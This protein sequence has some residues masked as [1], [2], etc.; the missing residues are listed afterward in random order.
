MV[1]EL[2]SKDGEGGAS[3]VFFVFPYNILFVII[4]INILY[5]MWHYN[6]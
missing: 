1:V 3:G 4:I 5:T 2:R 6:L